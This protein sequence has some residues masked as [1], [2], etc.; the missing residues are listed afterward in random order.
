[1][2]KAFL[3]FAL[4]AVSFITLPI[5]H[6][7]VKVSSHQLLETIKDREVWDSIFISISSALSATAFACILGIPFSYLLSRTEFRGKELIESIVNI[8]VAIPHVAAGI[9]LINE[10]TTV[11]KFFSYFHITFVDTIYGVI[12]AML[13]V[14][15]SFVIS[16]AIVGFNSVSKEL[17]M[18]SRSLG[19][20]EIYT[21][22]HITFPLALPSILRGAVLSFARGISEVGALL[23]L[24]YFPKTAPIL[25]YERFEEYGLNSARPITALVI[26][27]SLFIFFCL[28]YLTKRYAKGLE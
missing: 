5:I 21:F 1:M 10:K 15:I 24:A 13:F 14:S 19:A 11:G 18:V 20:S 25:M 27:V 2:R 28:L 3:L 4:L 23:I 6:I 22:W 16:S 12:V 9:A 26:L 7:F 8:P 17:E